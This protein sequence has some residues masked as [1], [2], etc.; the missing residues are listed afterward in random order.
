VN[1]KRMK[2]KKINGGKIVYKAQTK[3]GKTKI[4][5]ELERD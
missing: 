2:K 1:A 5:L 4:K 3:R